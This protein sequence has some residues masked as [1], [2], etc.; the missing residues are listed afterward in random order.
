MLTMATREADWLTNNKVWD[1]SCEVPLE[2]KPVEYDA[3]IL[4]ATRV[5]IK[6]A[7]DTANSAERL[8]IAL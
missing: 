1:G 8:G 7:F 2:S 3:V 5:T 4:N 6:K